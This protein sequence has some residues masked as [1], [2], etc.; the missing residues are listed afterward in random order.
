[1]LSR[2]RSSIFPRKAALTAAFCA[3]FS[4]LITSI[5]LDASQLSEPTLSTRSPARIV[6]I[7][8][9]TGQ[10]RA[11]TSEESQALAAES[12]SKSAEPMH[13]EILPDG[14]RKLSLNGNF[15]AAMTATITP[16]G[17][18]TDCVNVRERDLRT[19][20]QEQPAQ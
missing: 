2:N 18:T 4:A 9:E 10:L 13:L 11:P 14:S 15:R 12:L 20:A 5:A 19:I 17:V 8:P 3:V 1:M 7:D 6:A 16:D